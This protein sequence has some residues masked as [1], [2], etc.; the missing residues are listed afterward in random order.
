[1][2]LQVALD[3]AVMPHTGPSTDK[4]IAASG[5]KSVAGAGRDLLLAQEHGDTALV[6]DHE[7]L[8]LYLRGRGGDA[9]LADCGDSRHKSLLPE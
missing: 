9:D 4:E 3:G 7:I 8:P 2:K 1:M 6:L 5:G